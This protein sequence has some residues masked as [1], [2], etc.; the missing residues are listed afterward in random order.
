MSVAAL[1]LL[2]DG[3]FPDGAHAHSHGLEAAVDAGRVCD[4]ASLAAYVTCRLWTTGRT[5]VA[6]TRLA[7]GGVDSDELDAAWCV[8]TPS[9]TARA[10]A[11]SLGRSLARTASRV[12]PGRPIALADGRPP[13]QPVAL[14]LLGTAVGCDPDEAALA[15]AH[16][17]AATLSAAGL[18]L[19]SL[20]PFD[21][22]AVLHD[23]RTDVDDVARS[24]VGLVAADDLP[25]AS[26]PFAEI[27]VEA[28]S[29]MPTRLFRS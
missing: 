18:R 4:V 2:A 12:V 7:A 24:T 25:H 3:R 13:V 9:A 8:R 10:T 6:A 11:R 22:A 29:A 28:Q 26:T 20:D 14:G 19:L 23:L 27:D 5:D 16:G 1:L 15:A 21:V 17:T